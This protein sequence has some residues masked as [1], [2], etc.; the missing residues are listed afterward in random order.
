[1]V[2][3]QTVEM[4]IGDLPASDPRALMADERDDLLSLLVD[5]SADEW[6]APTEAGR[7]RVKDVALHL[8]DDD[9]GWLSRGRD[10]D[11]SGLL[12]TVG[13]YR[14]FVQSLDDKNERWVVGSGG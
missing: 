14:S 9:L 3:D 2:G 8:L 12:P 13:D 1:V 6:L 10:G 11:W 4:R 5:L 7:W